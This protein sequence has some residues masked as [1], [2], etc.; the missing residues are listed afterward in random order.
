MTS[1]GVVAPVKALL[2]RFKLKRASLRVWIP[3]ALTAGTIAVVVSLFLAETPVLD[4]IELNFLDLRFRTRGR[5]AP[6]PATVLAVVDEKSLGA[7]GRWPWPRS[8]FAALIDAL[9]KD[10]A[11][12]IG[13]DV[14]FAEADQNSQIALVDQFAKT[15]DSLAIEN[16]QLA[17]FLREK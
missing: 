5:I 11:K 17:K 2:A 8:K 7:E 1:S 10:G 13:F 12:V 15:V 4:T 6:A 14:T 9:S 3:A 16:P